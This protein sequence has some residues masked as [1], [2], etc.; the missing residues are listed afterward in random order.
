MVCPCPQG[1]SVTW[2][3]PRCSFKISSS[4]PLSCRI[5]ICPSP[6]SSMTNTV[7][8]LKILGCTVNLSLSTMV[9]TVSR[10]MNE[11][12]LGI[13]KASTLLNVLLRESTV[14]AS[15][16]MESPSVRWE[17]PTASTSGDSTRMSPPSNEDSALRSYHRGAFSYAGLCSK[18]KRPNS[19]SRFRV[20]VCIL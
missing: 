4:R 12:L 13:L 16:S 5:F 8:S 6:S 2:L 11:R 18:I 3:R 15:W 9:N 20:T 19:V 1:I 17:M 10:C 7:M 14:R